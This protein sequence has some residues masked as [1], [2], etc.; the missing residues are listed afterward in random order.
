MDQ[1][2]SKCVSVINE[3]GAAH[4]TVAWRDSSGNNY[5]HHIGIGLSKLQITQVISRFTELT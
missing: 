2:L 3:E 1:G 4:L 5:R